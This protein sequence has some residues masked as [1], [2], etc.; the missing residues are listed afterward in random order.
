MLVHPYQQRS[1]LQVC[2][3][4]LLTE[5]FDIVGT[6]LRDPTSARREWTVNG[7]YF[8]IWGMTLSGIRARVVDQKGFASF[9][10]QRDLEFLLGFA[11]PGDYCTWLGED[12][13]DPYSREWIGFCMDSE[14]LKDDLY[15]RELEVRLQQEEATGA[16]FIPEGWEVERLISINGG[17]DVRETLTM[18][19]DA[20]METGSYP[21]PRFETVD[22]R[23]VRIERERLEWHRV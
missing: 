20:D 21:D 8:P 3:G 15:I 4:R 14:D 6:K 1:R 23:W 18:R 2:G 19:L 16:S 17:T 9:I 13:V 12:Y 10:N 5:T 22:T 11:R 7:L